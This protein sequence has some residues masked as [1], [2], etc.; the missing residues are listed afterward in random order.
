MCIR[1]SINAEYGEIGGP[2]MSNGAEIVFW[3]VSCVWLAGAITAIVMPILHFEGSYEF[4]D[5]ESCTCPNNESTCADSEKTCTNI[6]AETNAILCLV[7]GGVTPL[8]IWCGGVCMITCCCDCEDELE[9]LKCLAET[10][11]APFCCLCCWCRGITCPHYDREI[12]PDPEA[13]AAA[14][15]THKQHLTGLEGKAAAKKRDTETIKFEIHPDNGTCIQI[16]TYPDITVEVLASQLSLPENAEIALASVA[17]PGSA[18]LQS[19][20]VVHD[21]RLTVHETKGAVLPEGQTMVIPSNEQLGLEAARLAAPKVA[22]YQKEE[23]TLR[24]FG[25]NSDYFDDY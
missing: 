14:T 10:C 6:S 13:F 2:N 4:S 25:W 5:T 7:L 3:C 1:D 16:E 21:T 17:L 8:M 23:K 20:G 22:D 12:V 24:C 9:P 15:E 11:Y 18:T 19:Q